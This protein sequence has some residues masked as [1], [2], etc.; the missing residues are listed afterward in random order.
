MS[1]QNATG[2]VSRA[3]PFK[4]PGQRPLPTARAY[5]VNQPPEDGPL[6]AYRYKNTHRPLTKPA[7]IK[8]LAT[9]ATKA[10]LEPMQGHGICIGST[11]EY[12]LRGVP[13]DVM[14]VKG[15]WASDAFLIY[16]TKHAQILAPYMQ[17]QP[18]LHAEFIRL[19]MPR[20]Q[21]N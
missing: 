21:R 20:I 17:A 13:F 12:L 10:G 4:S 11:L 7:F 14:K 3:Q 8:A 9:A 16:L 19:T 1:Q 2:T 18:E 5:R 15:R 6:F